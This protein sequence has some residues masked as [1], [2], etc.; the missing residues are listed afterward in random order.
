[1]TAVSDFMSDTAP[2]QAAQAAPVSG[3]IQTLDGGRLMVRGSQNLLG[4]ALVLSAIGLWVMPG[5]DFSGDVLLMKL[6]L[7][8]TAA[9]IGIAL[10][11]QGKSPAKPEIEVDT[12]RREI[13]LVRREGKTMECIKQCK[14]SDLDRAE[15]QGAHVTL[16]AKGN[17]MLAEIALTDPQMRRSLMRG[18]ADAGKL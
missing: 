15:V 6:V 16:W 10:V 4:A 11:Q 3:H 18:L 7:S 12:I 13:R 14:F 5:S 17:V 9:I 1:M 8:L 2:T